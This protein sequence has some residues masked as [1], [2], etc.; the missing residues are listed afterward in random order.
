M[1]SKTCL[2]RQM[3]SSPLDEAGVWDGKMRTRFLFLRSRSP[4]GHGRQTT[5][6]QTLLLRDGY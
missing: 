4:G 5:P 2:K 1:K 6:V 3:K